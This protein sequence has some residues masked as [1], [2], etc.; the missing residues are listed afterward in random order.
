[1]LAVEKYWV[2]GVVAVV[3]QIGSAPVRSPQISSD[4]EDSGLF[5]IYPSLIRPKALPATGDGV[6][7]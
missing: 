4:V 3:S 6:T 7:E 5:A 1:M 2:L